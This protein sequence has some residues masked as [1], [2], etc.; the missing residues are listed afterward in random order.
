MLNSNQNRRDFLKTTTLAAS[1]LAMGGCSLVSQSRPNILWISCEDI[2]PALGCYGDTYAST[3]NLDTLASK[4][5]VFNTAYVTAP[6]CAPA[7]SCIITGLYA[8]S[9]GTMN[10]RSEI[11]KPDVVE[12]LPVLMR[13]GG[14]YCTNNSKT[15]Y[16]FNADGLWDENSTEAHWRNR[17]SNQPFFSVFNLTVS[18]E[19]G[20]N[21]DSVSEFSE[22]T[23]FHDP[24]LAKVPPF[25]PDTPEMRRI[26]ARYYDL[27]S[28]MDMQAGKIL[29]QLEEDG[30][31]DNT[32]VIFF[33]DH[34]FGL[35][36]YKRWLT[37][38]GL[39][40]PFIVYIPPKFDKGQIEK[41]KTDQMVSTV[42][43]APTMLSLAGLSIPEIMEGKAFL[44]KQKQSVRKYLYG[45]RDRADDVF[46]VARSVRDEQYLYIRHFMPHKPYLQ[47][48]IIFGERK[49][50]VRELH[51]L[52]R[53]HQLP[54]AAA[55]MYQPKPVEELYD[56]RNDPF[57]MNNLANDPEYQTVKY[58][59]KLKLKEWIIAHKDTG[60]LQ[61]AEMMI[62]SEGSTPYEM[63]HD[64][65]QYD[66][67]SIMNAAWRVGDS[68]IPMVDL[69]H[70]LSDPDSG[71]RFWTLQAIQ[72]R[73]KE[74]KPA[75]NAIRL[76]LK[77]PS[78]SVQIVAAE[79]LALMNRMSHEVVETL[80]QNLNDSDRPA[81]VL[82]AARACANIGKRAGK[83]LPAIEQVYS[84]YQGEI[85]GRYKNWSY[86]MFIGFALDQTL[87]NCGELSEDE[88]LNN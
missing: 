16:N 10:L 60:F 73:I 22:L 69:I 47:K 55:A 38:S 74:A 32:I 78:P 39:Q 20:A 7:R 9:M 25:F 62:R 2:S 12:T 82:R 42:D 45:A 70:Y 37:N 34:G 1:A 77:D 31:S 59:L 52:H 5:T 43:L 66:I 86:P 72:A 65:D 58:K 30:L 68:T 40:V 87:I 33:S 26:W 71:V 61:E 53:K 21:D 81:V 67:V 80:T 8:T 14:Y 18:H 75:G 23:Q 50:S 3:P 54:E 24:S 48:A 11:P 85:W 79:T 84:Q 88:I 44:G 56:L 63:A 17:K 46:D 29:N 36:R 27:V 64:P 83:M 15:D 35:P 6:I 13:K 4:G 19:G 28:V 57:E 41:G 51:R 76:L 49:S